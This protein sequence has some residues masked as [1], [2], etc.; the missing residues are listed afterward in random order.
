[1]IM[2][3]TQYLTLAATAL[4]LLACTKDPAVPDGGSITVEASIGSLTKVANDGATSSF[5]TGDKIA[6]YAWTGDSR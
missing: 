6:V 3:I 4:L 5:E 2:R 1:M